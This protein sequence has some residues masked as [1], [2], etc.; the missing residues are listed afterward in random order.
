[1]ENL[2]I[3][4]R[5]F[6]IILMLEGATDRASIDVYDEL[7]EMVGDIEDIEEF[8]QVVKIPISDFQDIEF[9]REEDGHTSVRVLVN[10]LEMQFLANP[11]T[12][13]HIMLSELSHK[14]M[15]SVN[16]IVGGVENKLQKEV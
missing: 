1:M 10:G 15:S 11:C 12:E 16:K 8:P 6:A 2:S 7:V 9:E 14:L 5:L 3:S 13:D 4:D